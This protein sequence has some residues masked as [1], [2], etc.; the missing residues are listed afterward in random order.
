MSFVYQIK[1]KTMM[2]IG[3]KANSVEDKVF[4]MSRTR[5]SQLMIRVYEDLNLGIFFGF[6]D[7]DIFFSY[8]FVFLKFL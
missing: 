2:T 4:L 8:C 1:K 5:G 6:L 3:L 7:F